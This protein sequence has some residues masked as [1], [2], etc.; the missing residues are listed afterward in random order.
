MDVGCDILVKMYK[1]HYTILPICSALKGGGSN[2]IRGPNSITEYGPPGNTAKL[3]NLSLMVF[4][5]DGVIYLQSTQP[6]K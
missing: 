4:N 1:L 6:A 5:H 3:Q 2:C